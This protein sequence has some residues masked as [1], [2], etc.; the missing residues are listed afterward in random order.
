MATKN[1]ALF[2]DLLKGLALLVMIEVHVF[3]ALLLPEIKNDWWFRYLNFINGL[4]AP[5]FTFTSGMVFVLTLTKKGDELRKFGKDFW[6]R[7]SRIGMIFLAAYSLHLPYFS[8]SKVFINT[9]FQTLNSF[10][11]VDVLQAIGSGL[12]VLLIARL[13][14]KKDESLFL[15]SAFMTLFVVFFSPIAW[16]IDFL[17]YLPIGIANYLNKMHGSQFPIFPWWNFIFAGAFTS[18]FYLMAKEKNQENIF[19]RQLIIIGTA[20]FFI[21]VLLINV[22]FPENLASIIP[23]PFF[24][25]ERLGVIYVLLGIGYLYIEKK[26]NYKSILLDISRE[27]LIVYWLHLQFLYRDLFNYKGIYNRFNDSLNLIEAS[28]VTVI[29][30]ILMIIIAN[31]WG[32]LKLEKPDIARNITIILLLNAFIIFMLR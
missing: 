30:I 20:F 23:H 13:V 27:S 10:F 6:R 12:L 21:S 2:I 32:K 25:L 9:N 5:A 22:L 3:N 29:L 1:R 24:F 17:K 28:L 19:A 16:K 18:K 15:F 31:F 4:V 26:E 14:F 11:H 7:L 8:F